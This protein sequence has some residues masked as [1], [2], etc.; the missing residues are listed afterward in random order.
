MKSIECSRG[1]RAIM[2]ETIV[3]PVVLVLFSHCVWYLSFH[4][5][6]SCIACATHIDNVQAREH[7]FDPAMIFNILVN[8]SNHPSTF[9]LVD[10]I[11]IDGHPCEHILALSM[12]VLLEQHHSEDI[13]PN[14]SNVL[15]IVPIPIHFL[16]VPQDSCRIFV[17]YSQQE[18]AFLRYSMDLKHFRCLECESTRYCRHFF[19]MSAEHPHTSDHDRVARLEAEMLEHIDE[20]NMLKSI[21]HSSEKIGNYS[22]SQKKM[23]SDRVQWVMQNM[24]DDGTGFMN[25]Y[26]DVCF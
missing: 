6:Y 15:S 17:R 22:D 12:P 23:L 2:Y 4:I 19:D 10:S 24:T 13:D 7:E 21:G 5:G 26:V 20:H 16:Y 3:L 9:E 25:C 8:H 1:A 18:F 14:R 11:G